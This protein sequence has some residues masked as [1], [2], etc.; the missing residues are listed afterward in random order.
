MKRLKIL[1]NILRTT[2]ADKIIAGFVAF[3]CLCA[4][5]IL[6][7]EPGV[8]RYVDALWYC[9]S[10]FSTV[11]L[12]DVIVVTMISKVFSVMLTIYSLFVV[13]VVTGVVVSFYNRCVDRRFA[14]T[15]EAVLD[16]LEHL[17]ELSQEELK[18][19]SNKV[20]KLK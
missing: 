8:S 10:I 6:I 18:E 9:Y 4:W 15:K 16:K 1:W 20:K 17:P 3:F 11:G 13:A 2:R 12:G 5:V 14:D 7:F 19:I